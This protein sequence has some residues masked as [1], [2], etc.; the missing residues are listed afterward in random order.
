MWREAGFT[1]R[2]ELEIKS[3]GGAR[4]LGTPGLRAC[5]LWPLVS[6][7]VG[8]LRAR[9]AAGGFTQGGEAGLAVRDCL[10]SRLGTS[11]LRAGT[12]RCGCPGGWAGCEGERQRTVLWNVQVAGRALLT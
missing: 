11:S 6:P 4:L 8:V 12:L 9:D 10:E 3:C 7:W 5:A 2:N 1:V